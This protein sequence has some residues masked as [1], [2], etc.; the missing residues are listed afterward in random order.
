M[1]ILAIIGTPTG[2]DGY[3]TKSVEALEAGFRRKGHANFDYLFLTENELSKCQGHLTCIKLGEQQCPYATE[4]APFT[5]AMEAADLV[6]FASPVHC[7]NVSTLMKNFIDLYVHQLHRPAFFGKKAIVVAAA[8]GAGQGAVLKYQQKTFANW[9]FH[10]VGRLGTHAG[11]FNDPRYQTKLEDAVDSVVDKAVEQVKRA[12]LPQPGLVDLITFR[13][14]RSVVKQTED[15]SPY[16][17]DHWR[18]SGWLEQDYYYPA[19]V[20]MLSNGL[21]ALVERMIARSIR[22]VS[23]KPLT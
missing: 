3:T 9:G 6:I 14:W 2:R 19:R 12:E 18:G 1:K 4:L 11:L 23:V 15:A 17:W 20:N 7:F 16:D 8:A 5:T 22:K 10:V 21:A 13:V